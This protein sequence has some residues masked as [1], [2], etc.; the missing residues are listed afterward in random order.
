MFGGR[1]RCGHLRSIEIAR[2]NGWELCSAT[3]P[4]G[5]SAFACCELGD[6]DSALIAGGHTDDPH[7]C[8]IFDTHSDGRFRP[9]AP[10]PEDLAGS[11]AV[12]LRD[13]QSAFVCGGC[14]AT[15]NASAACRL[16]D[17]RG[18]C[19][20]RATPLARVHCWHASVAI[21]DH[22]VCVVGGHDGAVFR[23][24]CYM[25]D[26]RSNRVRESAEFALPVERVSHC[27]ALIS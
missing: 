15:T 2:D 7:S 22:T 18:D 12:W 20:T 5:R 13:A 23:S 17:P 6:G 27:V 21:G 11:S 3:L 25:Y 1:D 8:L 9:A 14:N 4:A 19:W 16:Y 10:P 24:E 26:V